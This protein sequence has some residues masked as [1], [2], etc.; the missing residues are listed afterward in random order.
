MSTGSMLIRNSVRGEGPSAR[1][2]VQ[3]LTPSSGLA[4][5]LFLAPPAS[6]RNVACQSVTWTRPCL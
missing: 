2:A 4:A 1:S 6:S 5:G 3:T